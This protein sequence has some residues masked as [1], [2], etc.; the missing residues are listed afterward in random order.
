MIFLKNL[1]SLLLVCLFA[2][3]G[4][5]AEP[6]QPAPV[7]SAPVQSAPVPSANTEKYAWMQ[8]L[9]SRGETDVIVFPHPAGIAKTD[10][11]QLRVLGQEVFCYA[12]ERFDP[13]G[14]KNA[15]NMPTSPQSYAIFD[16]KGPLQVEV[17]ILNAEL[18]KN[19]KQWM[20]A[21]RSHA[22][23]PQLKGNVLS[24]EVAAPG[25]YVIDPDGSGK[26]ALQ[27][28][29][30][31][32]ETNAPNPKDPNVVYFGPGVH[33]IEKQIE[34][35]DNQTLYVAGGAVLRPL[36]DTLREGWED[37]RTQPHYSGR[38]YSRAVTPVFAR[39]AKNVTIKGHGVISAERSLPSGKRFGLIEILRGQNFQIQHVTLT[40]ATTWCLHGFGLQ[41]ST[42]DNVR[43]LTH[44]T[45]GDGIALNSAKNVT[46]KNCYVHTGDDGLEIK[47]N[48]A[49]AVSDITFENCIAWCD[50]GTPMGLTHE[51]T[52]A[53]SNITFKDITVLHYTHQVNPTNEVVYRGTILVHPALGGKV[54]DLRFEN[55]TIESQDTERP[56][57]LVYNGKYN[58]NPQTQYGQGTPFSPMDGVTFQNIRVLNSRKAP[59][60]LVYDFSPQGELYKN[61]VL[62][63]ISSSQF[64]KLQL[65]TAGEP[66]IA[67]EQP[68]QVERSRR[69]VP[70]FKPTP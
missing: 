17:T 51:I 2:L 22:I 9:T 60:I 7:Q 50:A 67:L 46:V 48:K 14:T 53:A 69:V 15:F 29:T 34:L 31:A 64:A 62:E 3:P 30:N 4:C 6:T 66:Q 28:F 32:P 42:I 18:L 20:V 43:V 44:F 11:Y 65:Q 10:D 33:D 45:N 59:Q 55:I 5:S 19:T 40:G 21:P 27:I 26:H 58:R 25:T 39:N 63:N 16:F 47:T 41:N 56:V 37:G 52:Q 54:S 61:F 57:I 68:I 1:S 23:T 36:P 35:K 38:A 49:D 24:F 8:Y 13:E 12:D 70:A